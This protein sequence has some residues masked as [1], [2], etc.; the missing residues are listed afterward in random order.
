M[1]LDVMSRARPRSAR[2]EA[3]RGGAEHRDGVGD[4]RADITDE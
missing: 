4:E 2:D 1:R 3:L